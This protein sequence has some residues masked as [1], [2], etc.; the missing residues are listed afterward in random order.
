[1]PSELS[2]EYGLP[3]GSMMLS[4]VSCSIVFGGMPCSSAVP[5]TNGLKLEPGCRRPSITRSKL[6]AAKSR[7]PTSASTS[8]VNGDSMTTAPCSEPAA[9]VADGGA[10]FFGLRR[11][12]S[13]LPTTSRN[14]VAAAR[15]SPGSRVVKTRK[16]PSLRVTPPRS[17]C[18]RAT[19]TM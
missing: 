17:A 12:A 1:L 7:P 6:D 9:G 11:G 3:V 16:P 5:Y 15:C 10:P 13:A 8:P 14:A 4:A 2:G 18:T 19:F